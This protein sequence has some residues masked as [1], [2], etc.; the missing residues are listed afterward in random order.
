MP[1]SAE[2]KQG[3]VLQYESDATKRTSREGSER[4]WGGGG[5]G[6]DDDR[7]NANNGITVAHLY[8]SSAMKFGEMGSFYS[9]RHLSTDSQMGCLKFVSLFSIFSSFFCP[10]PGPRKAVWGVGRTGSNVCD[11]Q[12]IDRVY[13]PPWSDS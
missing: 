8:D 6:G 11:R 12:I 7:G 2:R 1:A 5:G 13:S 3:P 4:G 9:W 10:L